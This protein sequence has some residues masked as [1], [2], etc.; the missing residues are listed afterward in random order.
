MKDR[1]PLH[2]P[3]SRWK[4]L[5]IALVV[6][7]LAVSCGGNGDGAESGGTAGGAAGGTEGPTSDISASSEIPQVSVNFGN[8]EFVDHTDAI[9]AL[10]RGWFEDV[11][12]TLTPEPNGAFRSPSE[13]AAVLLSG[14]VDVQSTNYQILLPAYAETTDLKMFAY[15]DFFL[16]FALMGRADFTSYSQFRDQGLSEQEAL[17]AALDQMRGNT[18]TW[19]ADQAVRNFGRTL[20]NAVEDFSIEDVET[21]SVEDAQGVQLML[22]GR[23]DFQIGGAPSRVTLERE[24]G[25]EPIVTAGDL[26]GL[27]EPPYAEA[28]EL[29]AVSTNGWGTTQEYWENN[30]DTIMRLASVKW[31][32]SEL[33]AENPAETA[34]RHASFLNEHAGTSLEPE[35]VMVIYEQIDPFLPFNE[36]GDVWFTE[37]EPTYEYN[38][39]AAAITQ[40]VN[41]GT[42]PEGAVEPQ[43]VSIAPEIYDRAVELRSQADEL[44]QEAEGA[45]G[46][47]G[48][49]IEAARQHYDAY[50]YLDA[51]RFAQAALGRS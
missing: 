38:M 35:D 40:A 39:I 49:L 41:T 42:L 5:A 24:E 27:A 25:F 2:Q 30:Q 1:T 3:M 9:L 10:E 48:D 22:S 8:S 51:V 31:R 32:I 19:S 34:D 12:I 46:V 29:A 36:Q 20:F 4:S 21:T 11:G 23:A 14:S 28:D 45:E 15:G 13:H 37:G 50:N 26:T 17:A 43:D 7:L 6:S 33:I 47:D 44:F 18:L 16:G